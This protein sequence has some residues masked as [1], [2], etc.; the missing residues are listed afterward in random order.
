M[1]DERCYHEYESAWCEICGGYLGQF[2]VHCGNYY[3]GGEHRYYDGTQWC[4]CGVEDT[5][6][7]EVCP[8]CGKEY[9]DFS[10]LGCEYCDRRHPNFGITP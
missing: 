2:C 5:R 8:H 1:T 6:T 9:E 4:D 7:P 3:D 10:D